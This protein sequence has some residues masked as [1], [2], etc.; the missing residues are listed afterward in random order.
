MTVMLTDGSSLAG[1]AITMLD[2]FRNLVSD[3]SAYLPGFRAIAQPVKPTIWGLMSL[4]GC[5]P[6]ASRALSFSMVRFS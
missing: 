4:A 2:A 3:R 6:D 1:S 5:R